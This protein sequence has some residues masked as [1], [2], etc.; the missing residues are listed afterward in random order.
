MNLISCITCTFC[1][2]LFWN[3]CLLLWEIF[4][5]VPRSLCGKQII[6]MKWWD[7]DW[8]SQQRRDNIEDN[9]LSQDNAIEYCPD[10]QM[11]K[12]V[13]DQIRFYR[14]VNEYH[15]G[16]N[17]LRNPR[18]W[19]ISSRIR[20]WV[21]N[22]KACVNMTGYLSGPEQQQNNLIKPSGWLAH[23]SICEIKCCLS[24]IWS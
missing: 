10:K 5:I 17:K 15:C 7:T 24:Y 20:S 14:H 13:L 12:L 9:S 18:Y 16:W 11:G 19:S 2:H 6:R 1:Y 4:G 23:L 21:V 22:K 8:N 3:Q